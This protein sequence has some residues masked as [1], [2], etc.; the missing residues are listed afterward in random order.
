MSQSFT[1][2]QC[3]FECDYPVS[4]PSSSMAVKHGPCLLALKTGSRL[5]K[6]GAVG[7]LSISPTSS[8]R[9]TTGCGANLSSLWVH[10]NLLQQLSKDGILHGSGMLHS[11][12]A[13]PKPPFRAPSGWHRG[14]QR[15]YWMDYQRVDIPA[16]ARTAY[17]GLTQK[18]L[19]ED[20]C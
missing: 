13:S 15:K 17:N 14:Q 18:R 16:Q 12:T 1:N 10:R 6:P 3:L 19:E 4:P 8:T 7:N 11:T 2:R 5:S 9:P 20:L